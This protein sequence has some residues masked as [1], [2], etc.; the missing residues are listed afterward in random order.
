MNDANNVI[1]GIREKH[2]G[3]VTL[4]T[5]GSIEIDD[6]VAKAHFPKWYPGGE[7]SPLDAMLAIQGN[8][9]AFMGTD[10]RVMHKADTPR[11]ALL[12]DFEKWLADYHRLEPLML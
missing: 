4:L 1:K 2:F 5:P 12:T 8:H 3:I 10:Y 9:L 11:Q 6:I 7:K